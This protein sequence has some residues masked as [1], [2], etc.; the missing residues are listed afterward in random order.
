MGIKRWLLVMTD[1]LKEYIRKW[2]LKAEHDLMN[3]QI[4]IQYNPLILDTACFHCQQAVEKYLKAFLIYKGDPIE[5]TH[6]LFF[7]FDKCSKIDSDF[8]NID[9]KNLNDFGIEIRY[10]DNF[11][12]PSEEETKEYLQLAFEIKHL[13]AKKII[14]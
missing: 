11:L 10:P 5:K 1:E 14:L 3:A 6:N 2:L 12:S 4:V 8:L 7:L 9:I 13:A